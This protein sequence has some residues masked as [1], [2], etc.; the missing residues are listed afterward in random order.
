M[1]TNFPAQIDSFD[2][3]APQQI[4]ESL[5]LNDIQEALVAVQVFSKSLE[6]VVNTHLNQ[7]AI[8][9]NLK[10]TAEEILVTDIA[11]LDTT[12][13]QLVLED[14][15]TQLDDAITSIIDLTNNNLAAHIAADLDTAHPN[16]E[17]PGT[18]IVDNSLPGSK[19]QDG[20]IDESKLSFDIG[21][22][23]E[24][25]AHIDADISTAHP[26]G[27]FPVARLDQDVATQIELDDHATQDAVAAHGLADGSIEL[28]KLEADVATQVE[29]DDHITTSS[30]VHG[31]GSASDVVGTNTPQIL[32]KKTILSDFVG[33]KTV[34]WN[35][36][37]LDEEKQFYNKSVVSS[38]QFEIRNKS[39]ALV[40]SATHSGNS[41]ITVADGSFFDDVIGITNGVEF[42]VLPNTLITSAEVVNTTPT[43]IEL[44]GNYPTIDNTQIIV[45]TKKAEPLFSID[46]NGGTTVRELHVKDSSFNDISF[47]DD[48]TINGTLSVTQATTLEEN[49]QVNQSATIDGSLN[50][51]VS[52]TVPDLIISNN[53][54]ISD[55]TTVGG[56]LSVLDKLITD[57]D[58]LGKQNLLIDGYASIEKDMSILG[59]LDVNNFASFGNSIS[60]AN[61][62]T[63]GTDALITE[64][65][66]VCGDL[67]V[68]GGFFIESPWQVAIA[69]IGA[70]PGDRILAETSGGSIT[71]TLPSSPSTGDTVRIAD[72]SSSW[73]VNNLTIARGSVSHSING[74]G[75]DFIA[76]VPNIAYEL[77]FYETTNNW[78]VIRPASV[79]GG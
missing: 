1:T 5:H 79:I 25:D 51:G 3:R 45:N 76:S 72:P 61:S 69:S 67:I 11:G 50:V 55:N 17:L 4:I 15:K 33:T 27:T 23:V 10:H 19:V 35:E 37:V 73:G 30:D 22:Q 66:E 62:L 14:L 42:Y 13:L 53:L 29:L 52:V 68:K 21:T 71:I 70:N 48:V 57:K 24:L 64:D 8:D 7:L 6:E 28:I 75:A 34:L 39:V 43:T 12:N 18:R 41:I 26:N 54:D 58:I 56:Q 31:I 16:G 20:S 36:Q 38:A 44:N 60:I 46:E 74:V 47:D 63:V 49:L 77:V 9:S 2:I 32:E 40:D 78:L 59:G 65:L